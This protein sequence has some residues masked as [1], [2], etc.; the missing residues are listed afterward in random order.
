ML[1]LLVLIGTGVVL[2]TTGERAAAWPDPAPVERMRDL[3]A[4]NPHAVPVG[5]S[6]GA[7]VPTVTASATFTDAVG[8]VPDD[9]V[10]DLRRM[11]VTTSD[12]GRLTVTVA[13]DD[14][15]L[16]DGDFLATYI[17]IDGDPG[18][19]DDIWGGADLS[20]G[21]LGDEAGEDLVGAAAWDGTDWQP[22]DVDSL[23][24][25]RVG[26]TDVVWSAL[27]SE[28]AIRAGVR[29]GLLFVSINEGFEDYAPEPEPEGP[30]FRFT[31]G[32]LT[33]GAGTPAGPGT[34][35]GAT[36]GGTTAGGGARV[37]GTPVGLRRFAVRPAAD[38]LRMRLGW[39]RGDGRVHWTVRL[40]ATVDGRA[41]TRVV[42]GS[43][44]P[45]ARTVHRRIRV[46]AAWAGARVTLRLS[47]ADAGRSVTRVR[48]VVARGDATG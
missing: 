22:V 44:A 2:A 15:T 41:V 11:T 6:R 36:R 9:F 8:D 1:C 37:A 10:I 28:A 13:T 3:I 4:E 39:T 32:A 30:P 33:P 48:T 20:V 27:A 40:R 25:H 7:A 16:Y 46:P 21:L 43:G 26:T 18:T 34:R 47:V 17:D 12:D 45:G 42:T 24:A 35:P 38:G 31:T 19:G 23:E 5:A 14:N 29:T